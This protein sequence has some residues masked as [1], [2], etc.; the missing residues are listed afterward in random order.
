[1]AR[2]GLRRLELATKRLEHLNHDSGGV[3][4]VWANHEGAL[5]GLDRLDELATP[6]VRARLDD[7]EAITHNRNQALR[8]LS[9]H[10]AESINFAV[11]APGSNRRV[12]CSRNREASHR[13][14]VVLARADVSGHRVS[15]HEVH[16]MTCSAGSG[17]LHR[18]DTTVAEVVQLES[19]AFQAGA[20][21]FELSSDDL[22]L[23][24]RIGRD[25]HWMPDLDEECLHVVRQPEARLT[26]QRWGARSVG[27][28]RVKGC[29]CARGIQRPC[30]EALPGR[31]SP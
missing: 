28:Q 3:T 23:F 7:I 12:F 2:L 20:G 16:Q 25:C 8:V 30:S 31:C 13:L 22:L 11:L 24:A 10:V 18:G 4:G 17:G 26:Q 14:V 27:L 21:G 9:E 6:Q 1:M 15:A 19:Q 5:S 29:T